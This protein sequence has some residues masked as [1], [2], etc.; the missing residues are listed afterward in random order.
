M[1]NM[2]ERIVGFV[3]AIVALAVVAILISAKSNTPNVLGAFFGGLSNLIGVAISPV[4]GQTVAGLS[5]AGLTSSGLTGQPAQW[6]QTI[7]SSSGTSGSLGGI[8]SILGGGGSGGLG[9]I[10]GGGAGGGFIDTG[11][12]ALA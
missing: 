5:A 12:L 10:L 4:T 1:S 6:A 9:G 3:G 8:G 2:G 7:G 11:L